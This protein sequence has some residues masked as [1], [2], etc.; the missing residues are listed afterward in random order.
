MLDELGGLGQFVK[1][2]ERV[3]IKPNLLSAHEP[4]RHITTHPEVVT[5]VTRLLM[6]H[7]AKVAIGDSPALDSFQKVATKT[8]MRAISEELGV[9]LLEFSN[10]RPAPEHENRVFKRI[11]LASQIFEA[12]K[13]IS[14]P[15]LK[16]HSQMLMTIGVKNNFG[17]VVRQAKAEWHSTAGTSRD[18]FATLLLDIYLSVRPTLTILDGIWAMEGNGP[19][20]GTPVQTNILAAAEDAILLDLFVVK[21]LGIDLTAFPV[22]RQARLR[23]LV[24]PEDIQT[25]L[26]FNRPSYL[27]GIRFQVPRLDSMSVIPKGLEAV[28]R[29]YLVSK[30]V[31]VESLCERCERCLNICPQKAI[32]RQKGRLIIDYDLCIRCYCCQEIC[33][34]DAITFKKGLFLKITEKLF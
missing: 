3:L 25:L 33:D 11:E 21:L 26:Q 15:K 30:P 16:T 18:L 7:G 2:G 32:R 17:A 31:I 27:E 4:S 24:V 28:S 6:D 19:T 34:K 13:V 1:R 22:F 12:D 10:P 20:N 29:K 8:G 9:P 23:G 14:I 5:A